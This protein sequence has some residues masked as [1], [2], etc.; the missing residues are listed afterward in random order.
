MKNGGS[1][2]VGDYFYVFSVEVVNSEGALIKRLEFCD[3]IEQAGETAQKYEKKLKRSEQIW[4]VP[5]GVGQCKTDPPVLDG[6]YFEYFVTP[7]NNRYTKAYYSEIKNMLR[8]TAP[9]CKYSTEFT[10]RPRVS[11]P[12]E[13]KN[14]NLSAYVFVVENDSYTI[15]RKKKES[16]KDTDTVVS[17]KRAV[18]QHCWNNVKYCCCDELSDAFYNIDENIQ[19]AI[20]WLNRKG[21]YT[22]SCCEGHS[23]MN[24]FAYISFLHHYKFPKNLPKHWYG[25]GKSIQLP[26]KDALEGKESFEEVKKRKL[27]EFIEWARNLPEF[28]KSF[29][30]KD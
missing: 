2:R 24:S 6:T 26:Y 18:C 9:S 27:D 20:I 15:V 12:Y 25:E 7:D 10:M 21:Y 8:T 19:P 28:E 13:K 4:F 11:T 1:M 16:V 3:T 29:T 30:I 22:E 17:Y 23:W 5:Y 14:R